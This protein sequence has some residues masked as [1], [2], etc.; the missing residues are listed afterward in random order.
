V[1][2]TRTL[3]QLRDSTRRAADVVAF[4]DK[5][6][7]SAVNDLINRG[8]GALQ[9]LT[10]QVNPEFRPLASTTITTDGDNTLYALPAD[11]RSIISVEYTG[12]SSDQ[13][14][15]LIPYE[16]HERA[17]LS[18]SA[19]TDGFSRAHAYRQIGSN[20]EL[21]PLADADHQALVWYATTATQLSD[22]A[23]TVDVFDRLDDYVIWWAAREIAMERGDWERHQVLDGKIAAMTGD[24]MVLA[25]QRDVSH[26]GRI[27]DVN[28]ADRYGRHR[29]RG[30]Y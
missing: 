8:L 3:T 10:A 26:P 4:T 19:A 14:T 17:A 5:H 24:I 30:W 15:W 16:M 9:R 22:D 7:N 29:R 28:M 23:D 25:R 20:L 12:D 27:V 6:P 11:C 2:L 1:A 21:L 13:K 18:E